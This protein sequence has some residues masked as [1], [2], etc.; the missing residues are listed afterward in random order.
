MKVDQLLFTFVPNED[1]ERA[2]VLFD[3]VVDE[4]WYA[5]VKLLSHTEGIACVGR[6][7]R[8]SERQKQR[9]KTGLDLL[10]NHVASSHDLSLTPQA[11]PS[12]H[13]S[14][15]VITCIAQCRY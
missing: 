7:E 3:I 14:S 15:Y 5:L 2:M 12:L 4:S 10:D 6:K 13:K 1:Y 8:K 11:T 9:K